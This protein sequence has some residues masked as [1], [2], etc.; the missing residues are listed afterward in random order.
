MRREEGGR[1]GWG[2]PGG[3][4]LVDATDCCFRDVGAEWGSRGVEEAGGLRWWSRGAGRSTR[5]GR[6][7]GAGSSRVVRT[8]ARGRRAW[9]SSRGL[10]H[11]GTLARGL[12]GLRGG[13]SGAR[14]IGG[15]GRGGGYKP[16]GL[17]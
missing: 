5:E 16:S 10:G 4:P 6:E 3:H 12:T 9:G 1:G 8:R 2:P 15:R 14:A 13:T 7:A 11:A 17:Y